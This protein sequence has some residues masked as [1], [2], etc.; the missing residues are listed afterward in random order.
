MRFA[1]HRHIPGQLIQ[2]VRLGLPAILLIREP[3]DAVSSLLVA[4]EGE[5]S[6]SAALTGYERF[7]RKLLPVAD[8]LAICKFSEVIERPER[9]VR[10]I[11]STG[12]G[13]QLHAEGLGPSDRD[14]ILAEIARFHRNRD[15]AEASYSVPDDLRSAAIESAR[16]SVEREPRLPAARSAYAE[17]LER[18]NEV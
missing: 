2:A 13:S 9:M 8:R 3:E 6:A 11:P 10:A 16:R 14:A 5:L 4:F 1:H 7:H 15:R 18:R 12:G 17:I